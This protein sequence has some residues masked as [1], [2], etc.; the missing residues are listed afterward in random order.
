MRSAALERA[1]EPVQEL[2][3]LLLPC[4]CLCEERGVDQAEA[5]DDFD[6]SF[7]FCM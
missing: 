3:D 5:S 2:S 6:I 4:L 7:E 1:D